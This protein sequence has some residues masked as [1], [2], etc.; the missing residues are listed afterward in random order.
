MNLELTNP[1]AQS[2][3]ETIDCSLDSYASIVKFN[4]GGL[5][6]GHFIA[7][8]RSDGCISI[9]DFETKGTIKFFEGHVK[10]ITSICWSKNGRYLL[11]ASKDWNVIIW[12]VE[13]GERRDAVR[14]DA[15]VTNAQFHPRNSKV[16][17]ATLQNQADAMLIDLRKQRGG[18]WLLEAEQEDDMDTTDDQAPKKAPRRRNAAT[19]VTFNTTGELIF[20]GTSQGSLHIYETATRQLLHTEIVS[21][22]S[23]LRGLRFDKRG[24]SL[25]VNSGD[26][27][28][29]IYAMDA[30]D[31][32]M[33][34][35]HKFT[36]LIS[37]TPWKDCAFSPDGDY[38]IGGADS[39]SSHNVYIW[40]VATG[41]LTKILEGPKDPLEAIDWH[42]L[43]PIVI[44]ASSLGLIH[45]WVTSTTESW[46]AYAPGFEELQENVEYQEAEDEFDIE[47]ET[48][49]KQRKQDEQDFPVD[50][51][52][53]DRPATPPLDDYA[54]ESPDE[55]AFEFYPTVA[56][57][58]RGRLE[59]L[60]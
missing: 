15:P 16:L 57:P 14:C 45:V 49:V 50:A 29:R 24:A 46:S 52:T 59:E 13:T 39:S 32:S 58:G 54:D 60:V 19:A 43:K 27:C 44:S 36:D 7:V 8:G 41:T 1:F 38:V 6:A 5:F 35:Q 33:I 40:D 22:N 2:F 21:P 26:R 48:I 56:G 4:S 53:I 11:S 20:V 12:D 28:V 34:M 30:Q 17:V 42:P 9:I 18:R 25:V 3:P 31:G 37:R 55:D 51:F 10:A 47:D 23:A